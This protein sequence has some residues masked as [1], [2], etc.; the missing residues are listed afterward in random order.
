[1]SFILQASN[2]SSENR[3]QLLF[4][5]LLQKPHQTAN[6]SLLD[7]LENISH[8]KELIE[9]LRSQFKLEGNTGRL[10]RQSM[11]PI[12]TK[13]YQ[14]LTRFELKCAT[15]D[16]QVLKSLTTCQSLEHLILEQVGTTGV[17]EDTGYFSALKYFYFDNFVP[18]L[19]LSTDE[20]LLHYFR[21]L[22]WNNHY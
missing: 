5:I 14:H 19:N 6:T 2:L 11:F 4:S 22:S 18:N 15:V 8:P 1:M 20:E 7:S 16:V 12:H 17:F 13:Q 9:A 21:N 10:I 3:N